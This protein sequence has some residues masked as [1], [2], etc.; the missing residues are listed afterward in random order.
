[1][2]K[3]VVSYTNSEDRG[4]AE[5]LV[6]VLDKV[7]SRLVYGKVSGDGV[8]L[9]AYS[10]RPPLV[11]ECVAR[12]DIMEMPKSGGPDA[13]VKY[14]LDGLTYND[15]PFAAIQAQW[16]YVLYPAPEPV[17]PQ[18]DTNTTGVI[19]RELDIERDDHGNPID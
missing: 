1:M 18:P 9:N 5:N 17:A 12:Q 15:Y 8:Q 19:I 16:K 7:G 6:A 2:M 11:L 10:G 13:F 3:V 4:L 14:T